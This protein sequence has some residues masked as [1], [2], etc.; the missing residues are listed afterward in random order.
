MYLRA[1]KRKR[2][3]ELEGFVHI[4]RERLPK[5]VHLLLHLRHWPRRRA[6]FQDAHV[7]DKELARIVV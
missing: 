3:L 6:L 1:T 5:V 7:A 2:W 4:R